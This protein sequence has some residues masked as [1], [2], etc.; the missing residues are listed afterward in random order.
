MEI[1]ELKAFS[2]QDVQDLDI[3]MQELSSRLGMTEERLQCVVSAPDSHLFIAREEDG[4]I[5]GCAT[6]VLY[7]APS[8]RKGFI[9]D[10]VVSSKHRRKHIAKDILMAILEYAADYKPIELQLTSKPERIAA[11]LL[12][13]T[14]WFERVNTNCY[15]I[16]L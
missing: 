7:E 14:L 12:Y 15:R 16:K 8:A 13:Q 9:E 11:N 5:I 3:L 4:H 1:S 10:V 6:L 2:A